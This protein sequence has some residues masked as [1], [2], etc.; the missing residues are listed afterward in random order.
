MFT[1]LP[2]L[3]NLYANDSRTLPLLFVQMFVTRFALSYFVVVTAPF[4]YVSVVRRP[5]WSYPKD[6]DGPSL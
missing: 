2:A 1:R 5:S 3:S 4:G 6:Q